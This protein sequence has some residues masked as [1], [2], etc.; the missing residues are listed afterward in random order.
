MAIESS[1]VYILKMVVVHSYVSLPEGNLGDL[2][3]ELSF[4]N[5]ESNE[6]RIFEI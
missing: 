6:G 5:Y 1:L 3:G 4:Q 2:I